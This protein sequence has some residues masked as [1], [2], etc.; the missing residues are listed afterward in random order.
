MRFRSSVP[1]GCAL[2]A[3]AW[4]R[5]GAVVVTLSVPEGVEAPTGT[6]ERAADDAC[7]VETR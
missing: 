3:P 6:A 1:P 2:V 4:E 5:T 7:P